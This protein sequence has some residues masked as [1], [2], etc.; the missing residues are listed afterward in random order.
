MPL[1]ILAGLPVI[2]LGVFSIFGYGAAPPAK[3]S[4]RAHSWVILHEGL[5]EEK[6]AKRVEAVRALSLLA[7]DREAVRLSQRAL[8]D[9]N[10]EVRTAAAATL[11]QLK[12][13]SAIPALREA[14]SDEEVSVT[15]A[16]AYSLLTMKDKS[17]YGIY[18]AILMGDKKGS[19]GMIQSQLD[20]L[21]DPKKLATLGL[22]EGL[23]F[24][25][26]GGMGLQAYRT[27]AKNDNSPVR[28]AAARFL[29]RDPD[30]ISTDALVQTALTDKNELVRQ[31]A[32]DAL[33]ERGDRKCIGLLTKNLEDEKEA[34]RYR[35]AATIIRLSQAPA[36]QRKKN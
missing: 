6:S 36:S 18:Y 30:P 21:K 24:V 15:L 23:G 25:P 9:K 35:T 20:R 4:P 33:A 8:E 2:V 16:A 13:R 31:A 22:E 29:A 32:L 27:V 28:A 1:R 10:A 5:A 11:G 7:G 12:V 19:E 3:V 14:L 17:A 26:F 34:V